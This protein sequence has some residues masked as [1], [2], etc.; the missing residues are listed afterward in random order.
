MEKVLR[1]PDS[2]GN[3]VPAPPVEASVRLSLPDPE[4]LAVVP[5]GPARYRP[6]IQ[7]GSADGSM[8]IQ[9]SSDSRTRIDRCQRRRGVDTCQRLLIAKRSTIL[10]LRLKCDYGKD[11]VDAQ[12]LEI[13]GSWGR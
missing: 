6:R 12:K 10:Y 9:V 4:A 5:V 8:C 2:E 11:T 13:D 3:R 7:G 1:F